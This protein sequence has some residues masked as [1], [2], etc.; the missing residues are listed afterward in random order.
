MV[1]LS[2]IRR[3]LFRFDSDGVKRDVGATLQFNIDRSTIET[4]LM[5]TQA[6]NAAIHGAKSSALIDSVDGAVDNAND[7]SAIATPIVDPWV[8][9]IDNMGQ[10]VKLIDAV[11]EVCLVHICFRAPD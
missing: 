4:M 1:T 7:G 11:A 2:A 10:F 9:M 6:L 8:K 3:A 5:G